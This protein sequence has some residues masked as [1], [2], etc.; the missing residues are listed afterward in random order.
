MR[1]IRASTI[2][3]MGGER[4]VLKRWLLV[5]LAAL[6]IILTGAC[7]AN[8]SRTDPASRPSTSTPGG[9]ATQI[10]DEIAVSSSGHPVNGYHETTDDQPP[11]AQADC[12]EPSPAAV[13]NDIYRCWPSAYGA[14][15]CWPALGLDLLCMNDPWA[16]ELHRIRTKTT[17]P[18]VSPPHVP[19]PVALLLGD[20]THCR[21][22]NG[23]AWGHRYDD[24]RGFY[25]CGD[26]PGL[27]VLAPMNADPID[28][29]TPTWTVKVGADEAADASS[30]PP[31]S[32]SV[33][34]AWFA[35]N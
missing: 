13:S 22:R 3:D 14:D 30:P 29:S 2:H 4:Q 15:V 23:G 1:A 9:P 26:H 5:A 7:S 11:P 33:R 28:R 20:G 10:I 31:V 19:Q 8:T 34:T 35:S 16:K 12:T 32:H 24:L 18:Q 6:T 25:G 21:L 17:L 27:D